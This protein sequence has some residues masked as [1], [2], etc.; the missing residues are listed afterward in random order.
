M[1][2]KEIASYVSLLQQLKKE[3]EKIKSKAITN[4]GGKAFDDLKI[5]C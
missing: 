3:N 5:E 1:K 2:D 4:Y